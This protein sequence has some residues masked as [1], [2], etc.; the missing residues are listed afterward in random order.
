MV[1]KNYPWLPY[2]II[3]VIC[4]GIIFRFVNIEQKVYWHDEVHT[5]LRVAGYTSADVI[6]EVFTGK[7]I[8]AG[9][10]LEYQKLQPEKTFS[11]AMMAFI[12]HPEHPPLYYILQRSWQ[13]IWGSSIVA[14]RSLSALFSILTLP[15][16][17]WLTWELFNSRL[18][19]LI[20]V[21]LVAISPLHI[22]YAQEARQYSMWILITALNSC[23]FLRAIQTKKWSNWY[24]YL[25]SLTISFYTSLLSF[26]NLPIYGVYL[27]FSQGFNSLKNWSRLI[28]FS[29]IAIITFI[30]WLQV[31]II[32]Y[33]RL[34][35]ATN[36]LQQDK[37]IEDLANSWGV[38]LSR[39]WVDFSW[40]S[41]NMWSD[42]LVF[43]TY[44]LVIFATVYLIQTSSKNRWLYLLLFT[45]FPLTIL[46][47][48]DLVSGTVRSTVVRYLIAYSPGI[49]III[50]YGL[51]HSFIHHQKRK[52]SLM[53]YFILITVGIASNF[54]IMQR[55]T[56]WNKALGYQTNYITYIINQTEKPLLINEE[57]GI[58]VGVILSL[59][60][61]LKPDT[62]LQLI[63]ANISL[64]KM[65][66]FED[67]FVINP[68]PE[69]INKVENTYQKKLS[70]RYLDYNFDNPHIYYLK[71]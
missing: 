2:L 49:S 40:A 66:Q 71:P 39:I 26:L 3:I 50:A 68:T 42:L 57:R 17:Y 48:T 11:D 62:K 69:F 53:V 1:N 21:S 5:S 14:S 4:L 64:P 22:L 10:L 24:L 12:Q 60:H 35:G 15:V 9:D 6:E 61:T 67:I 23:F 65:N 32:N 8:T 45:F 47:V 34:Q 31:I 38:N 63:S 27:L 29:S 28:I 20:A 16:I 30:P 52:W 58:S 44:L 54:D 46:A 70:N 25:L 41:Y 13:S 19:S 56:W 33:D 37:S 36:W 51:T 55:V 7:I 18:T 59:C 43:I